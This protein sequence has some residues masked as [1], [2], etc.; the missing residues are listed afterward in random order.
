MSDQFLPIEPDNEWADQFFPPKLLKGKPY[1]LETAVDVELKLDQNESPWDWPD[2]V[3]TKI[4]DHVKNLSW[5]RYPTPFSENLTAAISE[6]IGVSPQHILTGPGSN[7]LIAMVLNVLGPQASKVV[8]ARPSFALFE[9]HCAYAGI[10]YEVWPLT[11]SFQ[12]DESLLPELTPGSLVI[13]ASP[14]NPT[15]NSL[16]LDRFEKLLDRHPKTMF[17]ADEAYFEF[18][19][20][21]YTELLQRY[22]NL[23]I[24]RTLS[25]TLGAAGVRLGYIL[26]SKK[27]VSELG[28]QRLPYLLNHFSVCAG[29]AVLKDQEMQ[30]FVA[31]NIQNAKSERERVFSELKSIE[32]RLG[33]ETFASE[34]NFLMLKFNSKAEAKECWKRLVE[35]GVLVRDIGSGPSLAGCLRMSIGKKE[36]N[37]KFLAVMGR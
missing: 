16:S 7:H 3:K 28:K 35:E 25:K 10:D 22:S 31:R 6:H 34:A 18:S 15:G 19:E 33:F 29:E 23:I 27:M 8:I 1:S 32:A 14:N 26:S 36:D 37:D 20:Q 4:L 24:I 5:N 12:Y 21:P 2:S 9:M 30:D 13:F 11:E 17:F